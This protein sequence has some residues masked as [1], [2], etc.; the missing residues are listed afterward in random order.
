[1]I[2]SYK[3][4]RAINSLGSFDGIGTSVNTSYKPIY[5]A[6]N[7]DMKVGI[8]DRNDSVILPF[9]YD[10]IGILGFG[11]LQ[12]VKNG[13]LGA[14]VIGK[15]EDDQLYVKYTLDCEY[16]YVSAC[17]DN[18][19]DLAKYTAVEER[20]KHYLFL[21]KRGTTIESSHYDVITWSQYFIQEE[22]G[23]VYI[24]DADTGLCIDIKSGLFCSGINSSADDY[25]YIWL[26]DSGSGDMRIAKLYSDG[27]Y[28]ESGVYYDIYV[29]YRE[30][31]QDAVAINFVGSNG[32]VY[33][34]L[35][36]DLNVLDVYSSLLIR[37]RTSGEKTNGERKESVLMACYNG[38]LV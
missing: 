33:S 16:D 7:G 1:M 15:N 5:I 26:C 14:A 9:E 37:T 25:S 30:N 19:I 12:L 8:I 3:R 36:E 18:L 2:D 32:D 13:K 35:D 24:L 28:I 23:K 17:H 20:D 34:L 38:K 27:R 31:D 29:V 21:P 22:S 11:L 4:I 6:K 10:G